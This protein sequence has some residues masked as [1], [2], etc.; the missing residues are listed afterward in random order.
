MDVKLLR[1]PAGHPLSPSVRSIFRLHA[2]HGYVTETMLPRGN[3]NILF[4][5]GHALRVERPGASS[6]EADWHA[7]LVCGLQTRPLVTR[8]AGLVY[9]LGVNLKPEGSFRFLRMPLDALTDIHVDGSLLWRDADAL[10]NRLGETA[11]FHAQCDLVLRWLAGLA[12][13]DGA[14]TLVASACRDLERTASAGTVER[15]ATNA[16]ISPRH[17]QRLFTERVGLSPARYVQLARFARAVPLI[18]SARTLT[19]VA[20][21]AGY[22]DQAHFCRDFRA[23]AG[24]TPDE[25]RKAGPRVPGHIFAT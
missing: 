9:T 2:P 23:F 14:A 16:G 3:V 4:N 22:F 13:A 11:S 5:F 21:A 7:T 17:L 24:M 20:A 6:P 12:D 1:I 10:L 15:A 8:P 25:Y 18:S 19:E